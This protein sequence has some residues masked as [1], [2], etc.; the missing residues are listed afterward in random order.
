MSLSR[1]AST[2]AKAGALALLVHGA[3]LLLLIFGVSWQTEHPA[4]V[5][6][7]IW[8]ALPESE[9]KPS[10]EP[11]EPPPPPEPKSEPKPEPKPEPRPEPEPAVKEPPPQPKPDIALEKK[12][13]EIKKRQAA[14]D[15]QALMQ[16]MREETEKLQKQREAKTRLEEQAL[17]RRMMDEALASESRQIKQ[18]A[19][20]GAAVKRASAMSG[21]VSEYQAKIRAK[22]RGQTRI[23]ENLIGNPQV[24]HAVKL[25]PTGEV[26]EV[27]TLQHSGNAAYDDAVERAIYKASPMPLPDDKEARAAFVPEML[28]TS[29]PKE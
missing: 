11:R 8:Q 28:L 26:L 1:T 23:P 17:Q 21:I 25:L 14:L 15:E 10:I 13:A 7:D 18:L 16:K 2:E 12:K 9:P 3:F 5:S 29:R 22:I 19:T 4:P 27:R 24:R 20:R 6:V